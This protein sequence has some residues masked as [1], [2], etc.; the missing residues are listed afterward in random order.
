MNPKINSS[1]FQNYTILSKKQ[2]ETNIILDA[3][4]LDNKDLPSNQDHNMNSLFK[5]VQEEKEPHSPNNYLFM[6]NEKNSS[7]NQSKNINII[8]PKFVTKTMHNENIK[9]KN[10]EESSS[11][12]LNLSLNLNSSA[13]QP[14]I[15]LKDKEFRVKINNKIFNL[16]LDIKND[17]LKL[18]LL[19][20]NENIYLLK[21]FYEN[22]FSLNDLK[23]LHRFFYLFDNISE[24]LKELE[25]L[26][27]KNKYNVFED[28]ENKKAKIQ[29]KVLLLDKEENIEFPLIQKTYTKDNLFEILCKKVASIS[30][31]YGQKIIKLEGENQYLMMNLYR[32]I[33]TI[34]PMNMNYQLNQRENSIHKVNNSFNS[35]IN[36]NISLI[37]SANNENRYNDNNKE[38]NNNYEYEEYNEASNDNSNTDNFDD[39]K[40]ISDYKHLNKKRNRRI[41]LNSN[42]NNTKNNSV[43]SNIIKNNNN[44]LQSNFNDFSDNNYYYLRDIK[45]KKIKCKGLFEI[46][47]S[48]DE[49]HLII[50]KILYKLYK[51]KKAY[52][53]ANYENKL[54]FS[55][56][57]LFDSSV[58]G[59]RA[60]EFHSKCD[61]KYNTISLIE[62]T[63]G[64]R[65]GGYTSECF[66][67]P[68]DYFDK[69]D[70]LS[71]VFSLDKMRIYDVI[72]GKYAISCDKNYGPYFRDDHI[73]IVDEF[74]T[75][76]SGTCIKGKGFNTT[77]NYELNSG[78]KYFIIKRLQVFQIKVRNLK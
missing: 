5:V 23:Q 19:E 41:S 69:K 36:K 61:Y 28:L 44:D 15:I 57:N 4:Q 62:T 64:H 12:N 34:N 18:K 21:F 73:C 11:L 6:N 59:D 60:S 8:K 55:L 70:N 75:K 24:T 17:I 74:F 35:N 48:P 78:K 76:E 49:L 45:S 42:G 46:I 40:E 14:Q 51:Y 33:N 39:E 3:S 77:K 66:E 54:Q 1:N 20:I 52:N 2:I 26:L 29:I 71:F 72:K 47:H 13:F 58:N 27:M 22:N 32:V 67:S 65:F 43:T 7:K 37:K 38:N 68:N 16:I 56:L 25:K 53:I 9:L 50:N 30:S 63:N 31:D 10:V